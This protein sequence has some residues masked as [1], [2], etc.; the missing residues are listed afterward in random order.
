MDST[1]N[2]EFSVDHAAIIENNP[3]GFFLF[4]VISLTLSFLCLHLLNTLDDTPDSTTANA[5]HVILIDSCVT[6]FEH[7]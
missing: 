3:I 4:C 2:Q 1:E 5:P 7:I 6:T